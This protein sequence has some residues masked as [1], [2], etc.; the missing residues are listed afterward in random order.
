[1]IYIFGESSGTFKLTNCIFDSCAT[2]GYFACLF[3]IFV[4]IEGGGGISITKTKFHVYGCCL[5]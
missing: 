5:I 3:Y 1:V 2:T 4:L